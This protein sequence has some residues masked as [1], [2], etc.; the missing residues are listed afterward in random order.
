M[1]VFVGHL[2]GFIVRKKILLNLT[3][4]LGTI[5]FVVFS[6]QTATPSSPSVISRLDFLASACGGYH[7][8]S[9]SS[10]S[11]L[12]VHS[13]MLHHLGFIL[14]PQ[15]FLYCFVPKVATR[16]ILT[17][18]TSLD[19]RARRTHS[20][21]SQLHHRL[22]D[23]VQSRRIVSAASSVEHCQWPSASL[24]VLEL[25]LPAERKKCDR[26]GSLVDLSETSLATASSSSSFSDWSFDCLLSFVHSGH[27]PSSPAGSTALGLDRED[28]VTASTTFLS[29]RSTPSVDLSTLRLVLRHP[30]STEWTVCKEESD[31][32]SFRGISQLRSLAE[33][34]ASL[35]V[36]QSVS[37][38]S[39]QVQLHRQ[40]RNHWSPISDW[41]PANGIERTRTP[42]DGRKIMIERCTRNSPIPTYCFLKSFDREDF[43]L[44]HYR[45]EDSFD[46]QRRSI[47]CSREHLR[48]FRKL[49]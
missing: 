19:I 4:L 25:L 20:F 21:F 26:S 23:A 12:I 1:E 31:F 39:I 37:R 49:I 45:L 33:R 30:F 22:V 16:T 15:S 14:R 38:L 43:R 40:V 5:A 46:V 41:M 8:L 24:V 47:N 48:S 17:F 29:P 34:R 9:R 42:L 6:C 28:R 11:N 7:D 36:L 18:L 3:Y 32:R 2:V 27:S 13:E 35:S 44:F 10:L